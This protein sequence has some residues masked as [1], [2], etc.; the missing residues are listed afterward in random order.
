VVA[1]GA[2]AMALGAPG[3]ALAQTATP[4]SAATAS[5]SSS[6][7]TTPSASPTFRTPGLDGSVTGSSTRGQTLDIRV[8]ATMPGGWEGLHQVEVSLAV[9]G[10][11][12]DRVD[13]DIENA[14]VAIDGHQIAV[15]TGAVGAGTYLQIDGA[16]VILTTGGGALSLRIDAEVLRTI[17]DGARFRLSVTSDRGMTATVVRD[18]AAPPS[19]GLTWGTVAT[20]VIV[21]LVAGGFV[22]NVFASRRRPPARLSVYGTI[23]RRLDAE[24]SG[25]SRG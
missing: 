16:H 2:V 7:T 5:S 12:V 19:K 9:A 17:P 18:L 23:Q 11:E 10:R 24:R 6:P 1:A 25:S 22:G 13:Y 14:T 21:A 4:S 3:V 15:G 8:D 20:A